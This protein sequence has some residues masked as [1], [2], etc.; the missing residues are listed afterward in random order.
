MNLK[1]APIQSKVIIYLVKVKQ[2]NWS[3]FSSSRMEASGKANH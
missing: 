3:A 2:H 1:I